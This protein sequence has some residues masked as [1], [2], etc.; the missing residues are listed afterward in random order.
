MI[1]AMRRDAG[2]SSVAMAEEIEL[3]CA[4]LLGDPEDV[5]Y[6]VGEIAE[7][8]LDTV[9]TW[10]IWHLRPAVSEPGTNSAFDQS[11]H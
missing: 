8:K 9:R 11:R 1:R 4:I 2:R 6:L 3:S 5:A 7:D 10:P